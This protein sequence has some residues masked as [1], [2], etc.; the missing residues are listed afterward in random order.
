MMKIAL[1]LLSGLMIGGFVFA[2]QVGNPD[3]ERSKFKAKLEKM[4]GPPGPFANAEDFPKDYFLIPRNLPFMVGLALHHPM[5]KTLDLNDEQIDKIQAIKAST[6]PAV[7]ASAKKTK[8]LELELARRVI[9]GEDFDALMPMVEEISGLRTALT[10]KH[11]RC[12]RQVHNVLTDS[13]YKKLLA[14]AAGSKR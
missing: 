3:Q 8:E 11:L 9:N 6:V 1:G 14:Y 5:S 4:A 12:I 13:Q 7:I 10:K 2:G